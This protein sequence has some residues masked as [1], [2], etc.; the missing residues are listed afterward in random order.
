[1]NVLVDIGHPAHVHLAKETIKELKADGHNV[2]ITTKDIPIAK[3]LLEAEGLEYIV[4]GEK[5]NSVFSKVVKQMLFDLKVWWV[6]VRN[7]VDVGIGTSFSIPRASVFCRM[8]SINFDD[9]DDE[10]E[11]TAVKYAHPFSDARLVPSALVGHKKSPKAIFYDGSHELAYLH[12][13]RFSPDSSVL[14]RAGLKPDERFFIM[15]FVSFKAYHDVE[16]GGITYEQKKA[17]VELLEP[18]GR[19]IITSEK[20]IEDEFEKYRL[21]VPPED[22]HSLMSYASMFVGDSQTMTSEAAILGVPALKCNSF[23]GRLSFPNMLEN[24]YQLCYAYQPSDFDKFYAHIKE[25][26]QMDGL[27]ELWSERRQKFLDETIDVTS[28]FTWFIE[29]YPESKQIMKENPDYQ[30]RFK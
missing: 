10:V 18:Y 6:A 1:M 23:A 4:L 11:P 26:L 13:N 2:I 5:G 20:P 15:R 19:V 30:Y 16:Q 24:E 25:L 14:E 8:A 27:K 9:D 12:P 28:F 3:R 7:H 29:N 17:L 21:P 22:I